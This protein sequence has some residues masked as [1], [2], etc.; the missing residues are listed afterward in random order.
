VPPFLYY[1]PHYFIDHLSVK[2]LLLNI[3]VINVGTFYPRIAKIWQKHYEYR[4][5]CNKV[6]INWGN[7]IPICKDW[8]KNNRKIIL[9]ICKDWEKIIEN[10]LSQFQK[11]GIIIE[12]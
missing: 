9:P 5:S 10:N 7:F 8:D 1:F 12:R 11:I 4:N 6:A 3:Y 2:Y